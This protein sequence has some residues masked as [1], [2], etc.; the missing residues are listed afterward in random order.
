MSAHVVAVQ[1]MIDCY[2]R[3]DGDGLLTILDAECRHTTP[4]SDF[5]TDKVGSATIVEYFKQNVFPSFNRVQFDVKH[6][7]ED[8]AQGVVIVEWK[9]T[10][11]PK[12]GKNYGNDGA[13]VIEFKNGRISWVREYFD[14]EKSNKNVN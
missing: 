14:T 4:G 13:F 2:N 10:L 5:G 6:L 12:T 3:M 11:W 8:T 9:S 1:A 7:Y